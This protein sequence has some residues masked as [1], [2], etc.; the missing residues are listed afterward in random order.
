MFRWNLGLTTKLAY[1]LS[2]VLI[3]FLSSA[4]ISL[5]QA[6]VEP[7]AEPKIPGMPENMV[8][9]EGEVKID[10]YA[11]RFQRMW[12]DIQ[13]SQE[14]YVERWQHRKSK[15]RMYEEWASWLRDHGYFD[16]GGAAPQWGPG[17]GGPVY[18]PATYGPLSL[19]SIVDLLLDLF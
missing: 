16:D 17:G 6:E 2:T 18:S 9:S 19:P 1:A 7:G 10:Y 14:S 11:V 12:K 4:F 8:G 13:A 3:L 15:Y 5:A